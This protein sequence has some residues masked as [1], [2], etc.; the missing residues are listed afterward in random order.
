MLIETS[1]E[2]NALRL[3][4][5]Y[6]S[7][8]EGY[9][10]FGLM[11]WAQKKKTIYTLHSDRRTFELTPVVFLITI[12]TL[13]CP[14]GLVAQC[15]LYLSFRFYALCKAGWLCREPILDKWLAGVGQSCFQLC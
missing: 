14:M 2:G 10:L 9:L 3:G 15:L 4:L 8:N 5:I 7:R 11:L 13:T 6:Q 1:L 12:S